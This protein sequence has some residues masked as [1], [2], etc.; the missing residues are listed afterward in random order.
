MDATRRTL[1]QRGPSERVLLEETGQRTKSE[2]DV[3]RSEIVCWLSTSSLTS[4][5]GRRAAKRQRGRVRWRNLT[6]VL[7]CAQKYSLHTIALG[8]TT[9]YSQRQGVPISENIFECTDINMRNIHVFIHLPPGGVRSGPGQTSPI[10]DVQQCRH[11]NG[12]LTHS[13]SAFI[14][15]RNPFAICKCWR[16]I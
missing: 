15:V 5:R 3:F 8:T 9:P 11:D 1:R 13:C 14:F 6:L 2:K 4:Q 10:I 12:F 7:T 16:L